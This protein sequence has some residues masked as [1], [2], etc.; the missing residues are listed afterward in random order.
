M[1]LDM[2]LLVSLNIIWA[3]YSS[4]PKI[5]AIWDGPYSNI[6]STVKPLVCNTSTKPFEISRYSNFS[7]FH[8]A[9]FN[10]GNDC[11]WDDGGR[12]SSNWNPS[13]LLL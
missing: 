4:I 6:F 5:F 9:I 10:D 13:L 8:V 12:V 11:C 1:L 3:T 2:V 7:S